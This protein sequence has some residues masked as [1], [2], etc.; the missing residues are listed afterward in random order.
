MLVAAIPPAP[1]TASI[2]PVAVSQTVNFIV[3]SR[4]SDLHVSY[5]MPP[6]QPVS[7]I[8]PYLQ[9]GETFQWVVVSSPFTS[10]VPRQMIAPTAQPIDLFGLGVYYDLFFL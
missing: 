5:V 9:P 8:I 6:K 4:T 7:K 3:V 1:V 10:D 2:H